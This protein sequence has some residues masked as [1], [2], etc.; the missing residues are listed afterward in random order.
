MAK[1]VVSTRAQA[2]GP[3][4]VAVRANGLVFVSGQL[5]WDAEA[6]GLVPGGVA[7]EA[8]RALQNLAETLEDCGLAPADV[9]KV[10]VFLADIADWP[11]VNSVY[12]GMF[13]DGPP[14]RSAFAVAALPAGAAV[15]VE[16]IAA[17]R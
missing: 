14:A 12:A 9:V 6:G 2:L 1:E 8:R 4:S 10:T 15:E 11:A 5:G 16:A 3:Y 7:A 17:D 13:G